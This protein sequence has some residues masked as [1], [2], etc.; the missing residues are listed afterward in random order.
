MTGFNL[1]SDKSI[2]WIKESR[3]GRRSEPVEE[4]SE[5]RE[6]TRHI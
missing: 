5:E 6:S 1:M 2:G 4:T 3:V